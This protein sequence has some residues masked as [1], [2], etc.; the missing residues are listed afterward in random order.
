[1]PMLGSFFSFSGSFCGV[2][3]WMTMPFSRIAARY[4]TR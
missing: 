1:M 3:A 4:L 2:M